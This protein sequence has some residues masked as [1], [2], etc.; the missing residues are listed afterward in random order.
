MKIYATAVE[1]F[2]GSENRMKLSL[3]PKTKMMFL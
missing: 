3:P 1:A 2:S